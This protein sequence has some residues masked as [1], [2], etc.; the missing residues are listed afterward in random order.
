[1]LLFD[2][3][4]WHGLAK[5][6]MHIDPTV[7]VLS[8]VTTSFGNS[9]RA[10][11]E[12][13]CEVFPTRELERERDARK[14]RQEKSAANTVQGSADL[15]AKKRASN[16]REPRQLNLKTYTHHALGDYPDTIRRVGTT[17][18][19]ST[20]PVSFCSLHLAR[21]SITKRGLE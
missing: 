11:K 12:R 8:Q 10:F 13:T 2:L 21:S 20:Q 15:K 3:A 14:R 17:D 9:L 16:T 1:M 5:L 6:R 19:Y 7:D 4:H 18:S